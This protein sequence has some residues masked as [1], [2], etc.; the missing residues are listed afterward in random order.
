M[1]NEVSVSI[2]SLRHL[3]LDQVELSSPMAFLIRVLSENLLTPKPLVPHF[4]LDTLPRGRVCQMI[5]V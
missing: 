4:H 5:A 3:Q 1:K 2:H